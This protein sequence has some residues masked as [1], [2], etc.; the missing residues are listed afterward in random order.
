MTEP[1]TQQQPQKK[2]EI[3][4]GRIRIDLKHNIQYGSEL[5]SYVLLRKPKLGDFR[6]IDMKALKDPQ[7]PDLNEMAKLLQNLTGWHDA[8]IDQIDLEDLEEIGDALGFFMQSG[9]IVNQ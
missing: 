7:N 5:T 1:D 8:K 2:Y 3:K 6:N 4:E 9:R